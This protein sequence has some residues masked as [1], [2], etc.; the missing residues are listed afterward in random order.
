MDGCHLGESNHRGRPSKRSWG[1][2]PVYFLLE[3]LLHSVK[4]ICSCML[5]PK[6]ICI[7]IEVLWLWLEKFW[8]FGYVV[9]YGRWSL[10][11][12]DHKWRFDYKCTFRKLKIWGCHKHLKKNNLTH[13]S[14]LKYIILKCMCIAKTLRTN[15]KIPCFIIS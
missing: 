6:I 11:R 13:N 5:S 15:R 4:Y 9:S 3:N 7:L 1:P 8:C 12:S 10:L 14:R 2:D